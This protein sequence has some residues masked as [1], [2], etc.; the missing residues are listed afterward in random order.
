MRKTMRAA[1]FAGEGTLEIRR[2]PVSAL[3]KD[4][5]I[6]V[7]VE[8]CSVCGTDV[9]ILSVPPRYPARPGVILGHELVG[10]VVAAGSGVSSL[11]IGDRV[12]CNPNEYCGICRYCRKNLPNLCEHIRPLGIE[13]DG[14]FA[15]YVKLSEACAYKIPSDLSAEAAM[16]AEPLAC[17]LNGTHKLRVQPG[18]SVLILGAGPIGLLLAQVLKSAGAGPLLVSEPSALRRKFAIECGADAA[19]DPTQEDLHA[20]VLERT[21]VGADYVIDM[22]GSLLPAAVENARKGGTV[23]LFG[24]NTAAQASVRQSEVTQKE[25]S[26]LGTWLANASFPEAVSL[27]GSGLLHVERLVT[28]RCTLDGL[29]EAVNLLRQGEAVKILV[30]PESGKA[31]DA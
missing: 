18:E 6:L 5:E 4:T 26:V 22:T 30:D 28:H 15:E 21:G 29:E 16:F 9:H 31:V 20:A 23:L 8:A 25:I 19:I 24:V 7:R 14:G 12:V 3:E 17:V 13:V 1:V 10:E 11:R 27:L 2:V